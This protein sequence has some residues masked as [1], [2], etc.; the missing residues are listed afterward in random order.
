[1]A[2]NP[3]KTRAEYG[4][5]PSRGQGT[6]TV[7]SYKQVS[8]VFS[9]KV[10]S[11]QDEGSEESAKGNSTCKGPVGATCSGTREE[12]SVTGAEWTTGRWKN[13]V[14]EV[15]GSSPWQRAPLE[16]SEQRRDIWLLV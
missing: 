4:R 6:E 1:M 7:T 13:N 14:T 2:T 11:E 16:G 10:S 12:A 3:D 15:T 9:A 5:Q 8:K